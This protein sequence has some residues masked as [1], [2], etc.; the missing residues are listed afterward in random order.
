[1]D[2]GTG[3][4]GAGRSPGAATVGRDDLVEGEGAG[5]F[6]RGA[7]RRVEEAAIVMEKRE[8]A[9]IRETLDAAHG[10]DATELDSVGGLDGRERGPSLAVILGG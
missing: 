8:V 7:I 10:D 5:G 4:D 1:M 2:V 6:P 9:A 3:P